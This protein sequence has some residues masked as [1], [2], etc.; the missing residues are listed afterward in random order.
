ELLERCRKDLP[1][2][3]VTGDDELGRPAQ[4]RGWLRRHGARYVLD[5]P[6]DTSVR[7]LECRRPWRRRAGQGRKRRTPF[8]RAD[9]WAA[10]QPEARWTRLPVRSGERVPP[11]VDALTVRGETKEGQRVGPEERPVVMRTV[12]V[13]PR[14]RP[15]RCPRRSPDRSSP[16]SARDR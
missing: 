14:L 2:A 15:P 8:C 9:A 13:P 16:P 5:V 3:W 6:C 11:L 1:H 7:D 10:R 4:F 12:A